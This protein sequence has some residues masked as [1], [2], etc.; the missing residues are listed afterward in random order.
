[1]SYRLAI[2]GAFQIC[3]IFQISGDVNHGKIEDEFADMFRNKARGTH[4]ELIYNRFLTDSVDMA[5]LNQQY[6]KMSNGQEILSQMYTMKLHENST[7]FATEFSDDVLLLR[8]KIKSVN[9]TVHDNRKKL[10]K[11]NLLAHRGKITG[12]LSLRKLKMADRLIHEDLNLH[13]PPKT[14]RLRIL[15]IEL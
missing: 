5:F 10:M 4:Y 14:S 15:G 7:E 2:N 1:L 3:R 8:A 6:A 13:V 12:L 9:Q 11:E